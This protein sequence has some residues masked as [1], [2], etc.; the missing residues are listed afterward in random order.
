MGSIAA[1]P[2]FAPNYKPWDQRFCIAPDGDLFAAIKSGKASI[3]TDHIDT[4]TK[5]GIKIK[6]GKEIEADI[7]ISATGF[8]TT[9]FCVV[10]KL[11]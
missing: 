4:F 5:N 8:K 2:H 7:I 9:C 6:S 3:V 1:D 11:Q 10:L